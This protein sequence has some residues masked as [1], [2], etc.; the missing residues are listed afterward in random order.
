MPAGLRARVPRLGGF[1][2]PFSGYCF[3]QLGLGLN[4]YFEIFFAKFGPF[5]R[6]NREIL[7]FLA[8]GHANW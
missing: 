5:Q 2:M 4:L 6:K 3:P 1:A 8:E 7:G